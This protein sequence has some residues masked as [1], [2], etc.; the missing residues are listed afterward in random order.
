MFISASMS[1]SSKR[2]IA[3]NSNIE[4]YNFFIHGGADVLIDSANLKISKSRLRQ[5]AEEI[6]ANKQHGGGARDV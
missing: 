5:K 2:T 1:E 6:I 4:L 3:R